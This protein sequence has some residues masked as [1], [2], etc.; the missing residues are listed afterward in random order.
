MLGVPVLRQGL[1]HTPYGFVDRDALG[2]LLGHLLSKAPELNAGA[3]AS[4]AIPM[5]LMKR[6]NRF[7]GHGAFSKRGRSRHDPAEVLI[8]ARRPAKFVALQAPRGSH[9]AGNMVNG[10][11]CLWFALARS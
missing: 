3:L 11:G 7:C 9:Y 4:T 5:L 2:S 6:I 1:A 8:G 10:G